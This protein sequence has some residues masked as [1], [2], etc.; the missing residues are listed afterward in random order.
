MTGQQDQLERRYRRLLRWYPA[1]HREIYAEE[2]LGVLLAGAAARH[3]T[4]P[5]AG[6]ALNLAAAGIRA[7]IAGLGTGTAPAWRDALAV[8]SVVAPVLITAAAFAE[9]QFMKGLI[10]GTGVPGRG[11]DFNLYQSLHLNGFVRGDLVLA[12]AL[13]IV[14]LTAALLPAILSLLELRRT[15]IAVAV[16][17]LGW[18]TWQASQTWWSQTSYTVAFLAFLAVEAAALVAS[19][20]ARRGIRLVTW[21]GLAMAIPWA[22]VGIVA[23]LDT[24]KGDDLRLA[25]YLVALLA[26]TIAVT[27]IPAKARRLLLLFAIP[28]SPFVIFIRPWETSSA[29]MYWAPGV[30]SAI[31][32]LASRRYRRGRAGAGDYERKAA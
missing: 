9:P 26:V 10:W 14:T 24:I 21:K 12:W 4:R 28:A 27:L 8:Y 18:C 25:G 15:A 19:D 1:G 11:G 6:E 7:R 2:M 3:A 16:V 31:A 23:G 22:A 29:W 30:M 13:G 17:L 20:G 5:S 32:F